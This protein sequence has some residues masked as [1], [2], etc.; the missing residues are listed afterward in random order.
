MLERALEVAHGR[1]GVVVEPAR[2]GPCG[3]T[4]EHS[5]A[6]VVSG[7]RHTT[8]RVVLRGCHV[9]L[10]GVLFIP[11][12]AAQYRFEL[13]TQALL[14][15]TQ[16]HRTAVMVNAPLEL[17]GGRT[18]RVRFTFDIDLASPELRWLIWNNAGRPQPWSPPAPGQRVRIAP[19]NPIKALPDRRSAAPEGQEA[20]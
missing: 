4:S 10:A 17:L 8:A 12:L 9:W 5:K 13:G 18:V 15:A 16:G 20:S 19:L 11:M 14:D 2:S 3:F 1:D 7:I 6:A